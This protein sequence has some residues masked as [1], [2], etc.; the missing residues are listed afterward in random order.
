MQSD[1]LLPE[2]IAHLSALLQCDTQNPPGHEAPAAGYLAE[3]CQ[4]EGLSWRIVEPAPGRA[5]FFA[6]YPGSEG[7]QEP[8][9]L[10]SHL[11]TVPSGDEDAW[12]YP[13][14]SGAVAEGALWGRGALDLKGKVVMDL[15]ALVRLQREGTT[16]ERGVTLA[17]LADEEAGSTWGM[18][19]LLQHEPALVRC[20]AA[21]GEGGGF[22]TRLGWRQCFLVTTAEKG[23]ARLVLRGHD[24]PG[25]G[26]LPQPGNPL[27][28]VARA[29]VQLSEAP[30][31]RRLTPTMA[32][33]LRR[34]GA[35]HPFPISVVLRHM[36]QDWVRALL[37]RTGLLSEEQ[38]RYFRDLL[39]PSA[40]PQAISAEAMPGSRT[41][42][43]RATV[44]LRLLPGDD[45]EALRAHA[46]RWVGMP[47]E[48]EAVF[49][50]RESDFRTPLFQAIE[51]TLAELAPVS[52][53]LP[54]LTP[55]ASDAY[56]L[57]QRGVPVYGFMPLRTMRA[58][59]V[60][61]LVHG[62][63]ERILLD[64][65]AFGREAI[66][67]TVLRYCHAAHSP[68]SRADTETMV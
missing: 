7:D 22:P 65:F 1:D 20:A 64:D 67:R 17:A 10:L 14:L 68:A 57:A 15:M 23:A 63:D 36:D 45:L 31:P 42:T 46:A 44:V 29:I 59:E 49:P 56:Y 13:P 52:P 6:F 12:R 8:L 4:R 24:R 48:I 26:A 58:E 50:A 38:D 35:A 43:A 55:T 30:W 51:D 37:K 54:F 11:D 33:F 16:L 32:E 3:I 27:R 25:H 66:C 2:A 5:N 21:L 53:V 61:R 39:H 9:L 47:V 41:E 62:V 18:R 60:G 19:W 28:T 40:T 34:L